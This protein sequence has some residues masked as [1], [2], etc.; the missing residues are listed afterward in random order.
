MRMIDSQ[1][2]LPA[3]ALRS[4]MRAPPA[5]VAGLLAVTGAALVAWVAVRRPDWYRPLFAIVLAANLLIVAV[6]WPRAAVVLTLLFLPFLALLRRLLI[7]DAGWSPYDPLVVVGPLVA[8]ALIF[9]L[10]IVERIQF[11]RDILS[12]LVYALLALAVIQVFNPLGPGVLAGLGGLLFLAVPLLWFV[13]G[14]ELADRR[15]VIT[16]IYSV[17]LAAIATTAYG[18]WQTEISLP[19]WDASW[20]EVTGYEA[21]YV[22]KQIRAFGTFSSAAEYAAYASVGFVFA[23]ALVMYRRALPAVAIPFLAIAIFLAS[24]R[25][26]MALT[27]IAAIVLI[28]LRARNGGATLLVTVLGVGALF[29]VSALAGPAL[30]RAAGRSS[31]PLVSHQVGG[32]LHPLDP[33]KSTLLT[34][35]EQFTEGIG[36]GFTDPLG[37]G[38]GATNIAA[39]R[40]GGVGGS[41]TEVDI[42]DAFVSLGLAGGLLFIGILGVTFRRVISLYLARGDPALLAVV[43]LLVVTLGQWL[44]GGYYALAPLTWFLIG[45]ATR[46]S[47]LEHEFGQ[48]VAPVRMAPRRG[49]THGGE[50]GGR[51]MP[52]P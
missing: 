50:R 23:C 32:L 48:G 52:S 2:R 19:K 13:I 10:L 51:R 14:R 25:G 44:N 8:L 47:A 45:W 37:R 7:A 46:P 4:P 35:W 30:D 11:E 34:H 17:I 3:V 20:V 38:T 39:A 36:A 27:L 26:V 16:L 24:G 6:R 42:S 15:T 29:A 5:L 22:G 40:F 43:G 49:T 33:D 31:N 1:L 41:G 18:L 12:K 9:R 21:L 28:A